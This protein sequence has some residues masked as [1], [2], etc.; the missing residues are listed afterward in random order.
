M[1]A[2]KGPD[3]RRLKNYLQNTSLAKG[4]YLYVFAGAVSFLGV[5]TIYAAKIMNE[6]NVSL[7]GLG[8]LALAA[9][10]QDRLFVVAVL[11]F[12]SFLTFV[13]CT[14]F[15]MIVIG[16]RVLGPVR[17]LTSYIRE[18]QSGK[19]DPPR[20]LRKNDELVEIHEELGR[21]AEVLRAKTSD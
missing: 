4:H 14:A 19:F 9:A 13:S 21:L 5:L 12:V 15:F 8:D 7:A 17:A 18:M 2:P 11:F 10:I 20:P 6:V 1:P 16:Q 3:Q